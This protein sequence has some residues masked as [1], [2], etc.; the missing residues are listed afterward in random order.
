MGGKVMKVSLRNAI[1]AGFASLVAVPG[2]TQATE[3]AEIEP[4][5]T[6]GAAQ[7]LRI[8][9]GSGAVN[10]RI[11]TST[12]VDFYSFRALDGDLIDVKI[13]P[14]ARAAGLPTSIALFD[15]DYKVLHEDGWNEVT[16]AHIEKASIDKTGHYFVGVIARPARFRDGGKVGRGFPFTGAYTLVISG[17][18]DP[19]MQ[20]NIDVKPNTRK[21]SRFNP[22]S[23][24]KVPVALLSSGEFVPALV[25]E[26]SLTF[27]ATGH[28][29]SYSHCNPVRR[30]VNKDGVPDL[31]CHF[32]TAVADFGERDT[33]GYVRGRLIDGREFEGHGPLKVIVP[34]AP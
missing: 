34:I 26:S 24:G 13:Q 8:E 20:I 30:D 5:N 6:I 18:S 28:E 16:D 25:D 23:K 14:G 9:N 21:R 12:D 22:N 11:S 3:F 2:L 1:F 19:I 4:N 15:S 17:V 10:A 29:R 31:V 33:D 32:N 27:G 7:M